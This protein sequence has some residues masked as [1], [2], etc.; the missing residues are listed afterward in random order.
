MFARKSKRLA[1]VCRGCRCSEN[2]LLR[3]FPRSSRGFERDAIAQLLEVPQMAP[4]NP[5]PRAALEVVGAVFP[6][7][8]LVPHQIERDLEQVMACG[9]DGLLVTVFP[10]QPSVASLDRGP[11]ARVAA[12][13]ASTRAA[14]R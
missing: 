3:N 9:D 7:H 1:I 4:D 6:K 13:P 11:F 12:N 2:S 8:R 10:F 14:R 5:I